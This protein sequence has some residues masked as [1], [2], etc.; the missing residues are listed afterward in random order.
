MTDTA[1]ALLDAI[2]A[3][4]DDDGPRLGYA[5]YLDETAT[6]ICAKCRGT[7]LNDIGH[8]NGPIPCAFCQESRVSD[9]NAERAEF[10]RVQCELARIGHLHPP[11]DVED[12]RII[13]RANDLLKRE[14]EIW[15]LTAGEKNWLIASPIDR[16]HA[17][18]HLPTD[19]MAIN[20]PRNP[21]LPILI[22]RRGFIDTVSST[23]ADWLAHGPAIVRE[24]PVR[25]HAGMVTD[26]EPQYDEFK[27]RWGWW[28]SEVLC[29][30]SD[31]PMS[32]HELFPE[33]SFGGVYTGSGWWT[34]PAREA[35]TLALAEACIGWAKDQNQR[36]ES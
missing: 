36:S 13:R 22:W 23:L 27:K 29:G 30:P 11:A 19:S 34:F 32:L 17:H 26:R 20:P 18:C 3:D 10:I 16:Y 8:P 4:P 14:C 12:R 24:H 35:A 21:S 33:D 1:R 28:T 15:E 31:V 9:G 25:P 6:M 7:K 2:I 5:D